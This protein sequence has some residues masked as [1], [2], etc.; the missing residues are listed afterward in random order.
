MMMVQKPFTAGGAARDRNTSANGTT[1]TTVI[2]L[3]GGP[4]TGKS[5]V[6]AEI[7]VALK[8]KGVNAELVNEY[9]KQWAW[10][11]RTPV[12]YDQFYFFGKQT[13]KEYSL[14]GKVAVAVSDSPAAI[15]GV[16][17]QLYGT[18]HQAVLFRSM[19]LTYLD[20]VREN[21]QNYVHVFLERVKPYNAAGRFQTEDQAKDVD[22]V[23]KR[24]LEELGIPFHTI[25]A[26]SE[27][28]KKIISLVDYERERLPF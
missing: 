5:T 20:M 8:Q 1:V 3:Y 16:Y 28:C 11:N 27:A 13:R 18:P 9:V 10:E 24:Y 15:C 17:A 12:K 4:G 19:V 6:A 14:F 25:A 26:D 23:M 22:V 7:F 21:G 2:N